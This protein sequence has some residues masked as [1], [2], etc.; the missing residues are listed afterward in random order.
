MIRTARLLLRP[1]KYED[2]PALAT[3]AG[4]RRIA[5]TTISIPHPFREKD[6]YRWI[7]TCLEEAVVG[8]R[9]GLVMSREGIQS[10]IGYVGLHHI[11][12]EHE[13]AERSLCIVGA[14]EV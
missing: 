3:V 2:A 1:L 10:L 6:A 5:D 7:E 9:L 14:H 13:E 8:T 12:R 11:D 4:K